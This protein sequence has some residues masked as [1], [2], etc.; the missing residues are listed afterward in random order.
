MK[1][2]KKE[3][4]ENRL[5]Y[6][7][8]GTAPVYFTAISTI[9]GAVLF[10]RFGFAV[11]TV[12]F[13]GAIGIILLGH[14]ITI[15]TALAISEIATNTRVEGGG[16]YFIISRSFGLKIGST[17]GFT[18]FIS[19]AISIAF[20]II[21]F[22]E[23]FAPFF[24]WWQ[25]SLGFALPRQV[26]SVPALVLLTVVILYKGA[27][28]GM[29]LLYLVNIILFISLL[30][31]FWGKPIEAG[32]GLTQVGAENFG[33][34]HKEKFFVLFAICFPAFT[35]MTAGVGLSGDLKNPGKSIPLGTMG[36]TLTGLVVYVLIVW[37][38]AVSASQ[39]DLVEDQLI[40]SRIAV[41][42]S[43]LIPLGLGACTF[44]SA[45]GSILV[46]PRTLQA[47]ATDNSFPVRRMNRFLAR[48]KGENREPFNATV[49]SFVI[50]LVFVLMGNIDR[51]AGIISMFFLITYGT[52]C[53]ISFLN[54]F[55]S[56]P[57]YRP[58]FKSKWYFSLGGFLLSVWVMFMINSLYTIISYIVL[59]GIYLFIEHYN[60]EQ[61]GLVDI[62]NGA[63]F[64]LNRRL[65]VFMQKNQS[66]R[67]TQEWRPAAICISPHSFERDKVLE[68]MKWISHQHGFGT[69]FHFIEGY[70]SKQTHAES[71]EI[72]RRLID[73]QK[74]HE[75]ALYIDTMISPS[76]TSAIAQVIQ[77]PSISGMEN[78]MVV[79]E[80]DKSK[81][82]ELCRILENINLARAGNFDICIFAGS[83][84]P[85]R[86]RNGIHVWIR[87][88]DEKNTNLM[89]LLGYIIMA[90]PDWHKS[91]IKI[92]ITSHTGESENTQKE[93]EERIAAGRLPITL[94]NI[95]IIPLAEKQTLKDA[96]TM[97][98]K[99]AGLTIIGFREE[100]I[101]HEP[102]AFFTDFQEI[103][104]TLFVNAS[105]SKEIN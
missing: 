102:M 17:I 90:H 19:Q 25:E 67:E 86:T 58:R 72:L 61:K 12:G 35:G 33:F 87:G 64:Q 51:V 44:S 59:V 88:T 15:P 48:G 98:S 28:S 69:Y 95:E 68:L 20:Y 83:H 75:S 63:L 45:L 94:T 41:F 73:N 85:I 8:F 101:K 65:R 11:G 91:Q 39:A 99:Q 77:A 100:I 9:L 93:L 13:W 104:D 43:V 47:L 31:F 22:T 34:F 27:G 7:G 6:S 52:L 78:N 36:G 2:L 82:D 49:V 56:P 70:Y 26:I 96:I 42:G 4:E 50:A 89:I 54:H 76:Y 66:A 53:L 21:T 37:K 18:L 71:Q 79:F 30:F 97:H 84:Y 3:Q 60:K 55:G 103:G 24:D 23:A 80:F 1:D 62:F 38:L 29:K 10:L 74:E 81:P 46:A 105:Q 16:E 40:M 5:P 92:F 32:E 57:S 14:L